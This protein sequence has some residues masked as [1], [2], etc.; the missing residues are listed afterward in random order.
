MSSN[1]Y[2]SSDKNKWSKRKGLI[3]LP[4]YKFVYLKRKCEY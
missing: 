1:E 2:V 3:F 4:Q